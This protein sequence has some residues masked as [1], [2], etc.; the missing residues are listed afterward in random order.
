MAKGSDDVNRIKTNINSLV[1]IVMIVL[2]VLNLIISKLD[3]LYRPKS[4][5]LFFAIYLILSILS[6]Y[7]SVKYKKYASNTSRRIASFMPLIVLAYL[8]TL[9]FCFDIKIDNR[10]NNIFY[11]ELLFTITIS[12]SL[13]LFFVYNKVK[14]LKICIAVIV[15]IFAYFFAQVL[16]LS[17]LFSNFGENTV[18]QTVKSPDNTYV[19]WVV[20][21]DQGALGGSTEVYVRDIQ[22]DIHLVSGMLKTESKKLHSGGWGTEAVLRW[23]DNDTILIN[24]V[25]YDIE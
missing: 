4:Y 3:Y 11:Y 24:D 5:I 7:F 19:A 21:S 22:K 13:V 12:S 25:R 14:W 9:L 6:T 18:V 23:E 8:F 17:M 1:G 20:S 16:F 2:S 15:G 10:M